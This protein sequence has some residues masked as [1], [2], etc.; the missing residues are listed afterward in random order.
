MKKIALIG[1]SAF[2][3]VFGASIAFA[4]VGT[5]TPAFCSATVA[6]P[7]PGLKS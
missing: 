4:Q 3:T 5:I 7:T 6:G 1:L 2:I